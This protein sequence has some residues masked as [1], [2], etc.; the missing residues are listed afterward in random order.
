MEVLKF[1]L[2][3]LFA[4]TVDWSEAGLPSLRQGSSLKVEE[5]IDLVSPNRTFWATVD[6]SEAGLPSLRQGSSLK[7]EEESDFLVSPNGTFSSGFYKLSGWLTEIS[8]LVEEGSKLTLHRNGNLVLT[9]GVGSIVWSTNTFSNAGV[10]ARLHETGN[11]VLINQAKEV[12]WQSFDSPTDTL[13]PSQKLVRNTTLVS[14]KSQGTYLSGFYNF[15]FGDSNV[16]YL[17]YNGPQFSSAYW[18][19]PGV[20]V[21]DFGRKPYNSSRV[22]ILDG[23]G[24]FISSDGLMFNASDYGF[25]PKRRLTLDYDGMLRLYS[26]DESTGLWEVSWLPDAVG[27]CLV[28]GLCGEYSLCTYKPQP[29]CTCPY[30]F[31]L[32]DPSDKSKGCSPLFNL[33]HDANKLDFMELPNSDY[34]G[35]DLDTYA[36]GVSFEACRNACLYDSRCKGFGYALDGRGQCFPKSFLRNGFHIPSTFISIYIKIPKILMSTDEVLRKLKP[37]ELNCSAAQVALQHSEPEVEKEQ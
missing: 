32:N 22:A 7:V 14:M 34:Y 12:L 11:L 26:L 10:E 21:F 24:E 5:E 30:G 20:N 23:V 16:L 4:A 25:G 2:L 3:S 15:K 9:D 8:L 6:W 1:L 35:F 29:T 19:M 37:Y 13:L 27:V 17:V 18:P 33:I 28:H 36:L 31:S